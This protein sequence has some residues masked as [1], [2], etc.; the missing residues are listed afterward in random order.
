MS[1][2]KQLAW[3]TVILV[4]V[5]VTAL[6]AWWLYTSCV[7]V[8]GRFFPRDARNLDL[9]GRAISVQDY[10]ELRQALPECGIRWDVPLQ[11]ARYSN[12]SER[13]QVTELTD[14]DI[15]MLKYFP[16]LKE[17]DAT[18]CQDLAQVRK[19]IQAY[20]AITVRY[21]VE[22]DGVAYENDAQSISLTN[23]TR[24]DI[25]LLEYLPALKTVDASQC[26]DYG[27]IKTLE[28]EF[29]TLDIRYTIGINGSQYDPDTAELTLKDF[30]PE[31]VAEL[32]EKLQWLVL[33]GSVH[34]DEPECQPELLTAL[35]ERYPDV[36]ITWEKTVFGKRHSSTE[37]ALELS[38]TGLEL[39]A[40]AEGLDYFPELKQVYL[41]EP[42]C[43]PETLTQLAQQFPEVAISWEKTMFGQLHYSTETE[44]DLSEMEI[45]LEEVEE[46]MRYF[47]YTEKVNL[48][49]CAFDN[50]TLAAFREE[51]R[52][53]F[54][55]VWTI[56]VTGEEVRTDDTIFHSSGRGVNVIDSL[57]ADLYYCEDMIIVDVG[58]SRLETIEWVRGMPN[59]KYL[60]LADNRIRDLTP[61]STCKNL[62]YLE[63]FTNWYLTDLSPLV[64]CTAL[65][66]LNLAKT[67]C[68]LTPLAQMPW[69]KNL[70]ANA[71]KNNEEEKEL[72]R[73]SLPNTHIEFDHGFCTGGG[74]R[75]LQN[76]FDM[77][78]M[79]G[80]PR[81]A[82]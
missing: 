10:E 81:N 30:G 23:I 20:P 63:L 53:R 56:L 14:E 69:L 31:A 45:T 16:S 32:T 72:L 49:F 39:E 62:V 55:V 73:S 3:L 80:L 15:A 24:Q 17:V 5:T 68:D 54:K 2:K 38:G 4:S 41:V 9:T 13:I 78:D 8:C 33:C 1:R 50:E 46:G 44:I 52:P 27:G 29:P 43:Q 18:A 36:E 76:Y 40:A 75:Q 51:M 58:H 48:S 61:I 26:V 6:L 47:P 42:D 67:E 25:E 11:A 74:W 60:I 37:E 82:W 70:W 79:M 77:R 19:L 59:L 64:E 28:T 22:I 35:Y 34:L 7:F 66:D 57:S 71:R 65:E 21:L 12:G